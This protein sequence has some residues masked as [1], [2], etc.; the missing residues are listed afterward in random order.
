MDRRSDMTVG[1][2]VEPG[3][4]P[5]PVYTLNLSRARFYLSLAGVLLAFVVSAIGIASAFG[6]YQARSVME[7]MVRQAV[8]AEVRREMAAQSAQI[9]RELQAVRVELSRLG[10]VSAQNQALLNRLL[11]KAMAG[12]PPRRPAQ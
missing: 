4:K 9:E 8:H 3:G 5:E 10:A 7:P 11:E 12:D 1:I 6:R 2:P